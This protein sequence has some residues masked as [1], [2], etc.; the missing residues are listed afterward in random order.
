VEPKR[1]DI[2]G[3]SFIEFSSGGRESCRFSAPRYAAVRAAIF[4]G[5]RVSVWC[6]RVQVR[7]VAARIQVDGVDA[8]TLADTSA[9]IRRNNWIGAGGIAIC[10]IIVAHAIIRGWRPRPR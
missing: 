6:A 4:N 5:R 1:A 3:S 10:L 2:Y 9:Y 7:W 8:L